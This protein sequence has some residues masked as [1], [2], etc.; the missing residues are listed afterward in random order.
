MFRDFLTVIFMGGFLFTA[1]VDQAADS[2]PDSPVHSS[3]EAGA[4]AASPAPWQPAPSDKNLERGEVF[5]QSTDIRTLESL[6][7]QFMLSLKGS[8]PTPCHQLRVQVSPPDAQNEIQVEVYSLVDPQEICI[9]ML[10][11]F[12]VNIPLGSFASGRYQVVVNG[13]QVGEI[14]A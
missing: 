12:E 6:P 13:E 1:C 4:G 10:Q 2:G 9:Q 3:A 8:L 5:L 14:S 7:P 11:D